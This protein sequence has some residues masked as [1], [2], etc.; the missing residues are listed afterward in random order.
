MGID[1]GMPERGNA[2]K[3]RS[4]LT[5]IVPEGAG[6]GEEVAELRK[7]ARGNGAVRRLTSQQFHI[8]PSINGRANLWPRTFEKQISRIGRSVSAGDMRTQRSDS[9]K[10][11][12]LRSIS[13]VRQRNRV[14]RQYLKPTV[15]DGRPRSPVAE[16][17]ENV[18]LRLASAVRTYGD[19]H[20]D[21]LIDGKNES[22]FLQA[23]FN[24]MNIL[25]GV[26]I[27][28]IPYAVSKGGWLSLGFLLLFGVMC[29]YTGLLLR[30]C[31][32]ADSTITSYADIGLAAFGPVGKFLTSVVTYLVLYCVLVEF[33]IMAGDNLASL[34]P[35]L[36]VHIG[37][38]TFT[39]HQ[40][41]VV[42]SAICLMPTVWLRELSLLA[43]IS[44]GGVIACFAIVLVVG[45]VGAF[46]GVGFS[47]TGTLIDFS[48]LPVAVGISAFCFSSHAVFPSIYS[49]MKDKTQ[50]SKVLTL[51]FT[52]VI[53]LYGVIA[54]LGYTMFGEDVE[55]QVTL[56]LPKS[57]VSSKVA[58]WIVV[59]IPFAKFALTIN[60]VAQS[61]EE[62]LPWDSKSKE[63][64]FGSICIRS[65]LVLST[66]VVALTIPF[67]GLMM[68]FIGSFLGIMS[69]V[70]LPCLCYWRIYKEIS[71]A[72]RSVLVIVMGIGIVAGV[73]GTYTSIKGIAGKSEAN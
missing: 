45:Y 13:S 21:A 46:G 7:S 35:L 70:I 52:F 38:F 54:V 3:M 17:Y 49:D 72:E 14:L 22:S 53:I 20:E 67:F 51:C 64:L 36:D 56:N 37:G 24:G 30:R 63:F 73:I 59:V 71:L 39:A 1:E 55:S 50:F 33:L 12:L 61:L 26:G 16:G 47:H 27:L 6:S 18:P 5:A 32:D 42:I 48:G 8:S 28:S 69:A 68:A 19:E 65:I 43:Y 2:G 29:L 66:V 15:E 23:C 40:M 9:L 62:L 4:L 25:A 57:L 11:P 41:F 31:M 34:F 58:V 10:E 44:A 60:P